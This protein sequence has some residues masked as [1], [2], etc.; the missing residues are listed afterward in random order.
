MKHY[1]ITR[2]SFLFLLGSVLMLS[3]CEREQI[4]ALGTIYPL[5]GDVVDP[6]NPVFRWESSGPGP[7]TFR[8]GTADMRDIL[9]DTENSDGEYR[10]EG[11]LAPGCSYTMELEQGDQK[12]VRDFQVKSIPLRFLGS[13]PIALTHYAAPG[14][15]PITVET[16]VHFIQSMS[17]LVLEFEDRPGMPPIQTRFRVGFVPLQTGNDD[18]WASAIKDPYRMNVE[19]DLERMTFTGSCYQQSLNGESWTFRSL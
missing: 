7:V 13:Q 10:L 3:A 9:V 4:N 17:H 5:E 2:F 14:Q 8:L 18:L 6:Q 1:P 19:F 12:V 11:Y 16:N 15:T